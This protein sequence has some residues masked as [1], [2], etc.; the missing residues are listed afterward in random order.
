[1]AGVTASKGIERDRLS[2]ETVVDRALKLAD[3]GGLESL[4]IRKLAQSLGVTPMALYWHFRSKEELLEGLAER[5]WGEIDLS[6]DPDASWIARFRALM[7]SLIG[8]LRAHRAAPELLLRSIKRSE[9][10]LRATEVAL[11]VLRSAGFDPEYASAISRAALWTGIMLVMSE[12]GPEPGM[13]EPDWDEKRRQ[14]LVML[15]LLPA[16][17]FPRVVECAGPLTKCDDSE[18]H[19]R[20]G[21]DMFVAGVEAVAR[22]Q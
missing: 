17:R 6:L 21:I 19:Y 11:E 20:L 4:T 2:Q 14:D 5:V 9:P 12:P 13:S 22:R 8:V 16:A 18:F 15:S 7:E 1:L 10:A 3:E